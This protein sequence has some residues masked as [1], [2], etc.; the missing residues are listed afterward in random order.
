MVWPENSDIGLELHFSPLNEGKNKSSH[1]FL[2]WWQQ[3][4]TGALHVNGFDY[5][6]EH[7][8]KE[9]S[10]QKMRFERVK[11]PSGAGAPKAPLCKGSC[12]ANSV[13]EGLSLKKLEERCFYNPSVKNQKIFDT[14]PYSGEALVQCILVGF[15]MKNDFFDS[16]KPHPKG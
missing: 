13:T 16:L 3:G 4:S 10:S 5:Y 1:Q 9:T 2:N 15:C 6:I 8:E 12:H 14:S 11:K 7:K